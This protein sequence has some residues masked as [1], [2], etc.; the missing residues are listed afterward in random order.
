MRVG[1]ISLAV[2]LGILWVV[3]LSQGAA[4]WLVWLD[5][6]AALIALAAPLLPEQNG[7]IMKAPPFALAVGVGALWLG[8]LATGVRSWLTWWNFA[9]AIAFLVL[10]FALLSEPSERT[11][12]GTGPRRA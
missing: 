12:T 9:F 8:A 4:P 1:M 6:I 3:G 11:F 10:G 7:T 5:F 2:G